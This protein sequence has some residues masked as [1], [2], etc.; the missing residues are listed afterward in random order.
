MNDPCVRK[1]HR[2][3]TKVPEISRQL[4]NHP[5]CRIVN[6]PQAL[7]IPFGDPFKRG[8]RWYFPGII[9]NVPKPP[10]GVADGRQFPRS[11]HLRV[12]RQYLLDERRTRSWHAHDEQWKFGFTTRQA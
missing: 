3:Q 9:L 8:L 4:V 5:Q 2:D 7:K 12:A 6:L 1:Q 10:R 11:C